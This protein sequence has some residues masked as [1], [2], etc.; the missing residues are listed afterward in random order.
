[1][2]RRLVL[3]FALV[4]RAWAAEPECIVS[5]RLPSFGLH[6]NRRTVSQTPVASARGSACTM[7]RLPRVHTE[8]YDTSES[9]QMCTRNTSTV[10][11]SLLKQ[12]ATNPEASR[13]LLRSFTASLPPEK[14]QDPHS[15]HARRMLCAACEL[16]RADKVLTPFL[17]EETVQGPLQLSFGSRVRLSTARLVA[18]HLH[19]EICNAS[20]TCPSLEAVLP[21]SCAGSS[22]LSKNFF[23]QT[24]LDNARGTADV[25]P[26]SAASDALWARKWVYCPNKRSDGIFAQ[27]QGSVDKATWLNPQTR[28][29]ACAAQI[30][31]SAATSVSV[32]FCLIHSKTTRLCE[33]MFQWRREAEAIICR[34]SGRCP[35]TDFFYSP[36]TF[37][38]REQ[39]FV[40][41]SVLDYY[42]TETGRTCAMGNDVSEQQ[43][44]NY[45]NMGRC[46]S[47]QIEPML[48]IVEQLR[49]G[50]R[51]LMLIGYHYYRVQFYL[52]QL[53]VSATMDTAASLASAGTDTLGRVADSLLREVMSLMQQIGAFVDQLR[54]TVMELAMSRGAGKTIKD[55]LVVVCKI[56]EFLYTVLWSYFLCPILRI[57]LIIMEFSINIADALLNIVRIVLFGAPEVVKV[58]DGFIGTARDIISGI[59]RAIGNCAP[60]SFNCVIEPVFG[61]QD[62]DFGTLPMPTRCWSSY[63]TF[64]GDNQQSSCSKADTCKLAPLASIQERRVCG[65]CPEQS[66]PSVQD[67]ACHALTGICTC[68]V[69]ILSSTS[70][71]TNEDCMTDQDATCRLIND[72]LE[73]S[74]SSVACGDCAYQQ[75]CFETSEGGV[76]ACGARQRKMHT[77]SQTDHEEKNALSLRLEELCL[78]TSTDGVV[79]FALSSVIPCME[80]DSSLSSC[81]W[82]IDIGAFLARGFRRVRRRL[83]EHGNIQRVYTFKSVDSVCRDALLSEALPY[84]RAACQDAFDESNAT[85]QLLELQG[86]LPTCTF[87]SFA[88]ALDAARHNPVAMLQLASPRALSIILQRHGVLQR[89]AQLGAVVHGGLRELAASMSNRNASQIVI[90]QRNAGTITVRVSDA[91]VPAHIARALEQFL[92][93]VLPTLEAFAPRVVNS[94]NTSEATSLQHSR[95]LLLFRELVLAVE[96]R[97][98]TG[99]NQAG[100]LHEAFSQ[101]IELVLTYKYAGSS[102]LANDLVW[103]P[104]QT[105]GGKDTCTELRDLL[106]IFITVGEGIFDGWLTL[107]HE[108]E[109]LQSRP[110]ESLAAAWPVLLRQDEAEDGPTADVLKLR[111]SSSDDVITQ[112]CTAG[113]SAAFEAAGIDTRVFYDI[114]YSVASA[115]NASFTCPYKAVQT[116]S[117]WNRRLYQAVIIVVLWFCAA[118]LFI[119][120][121]GLTFV[122]SLLVPF[123]SLVVMQLCYGYTWTCLPMVPVCWWQ[124]FT[125]SVN[126][127]LPLSLEIPDELKRLDRHCLVVD[128]ACVNAGAAAN[129]CLSLQR[130]PQA[131]CLKSCREAPFGFVSWQHVLAWGLAETGPAT[132]DAALAALKMLP[133]V[134]HD[135][136]V[137][138]VRKRSR[139]I[140][141]AS[142]DSVSAHRACAMLNTYMLLPYVLILMLVLAFLTSFMQTLASQ[143]FPLFNVLCTLG[144]AIAISAH[145]NDDVRKLA[146][147]SKAEV[148][149]DEGEYDENSVGIAVEGS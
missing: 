76:C 133:L 60:K 114:F 127:L 32:E 17:Q 61:E 19:R 87:C 11:C 113:A 20:D 75:M 62:S 4:A 18:A 136:L 132:A 8:V 95:R 109:R 77:C 44:A 53:L 66:N 128:T 104:V 31:I 121:L 88:D 39:Q 10:T 58:L 56:V 119:N 26:A 52:V 116:C 14:G 13:Q 82:A 69:P 70:C 89:T 139:T 106:N 3:L 5:R 38:L 16:Q 68:G 42:R 25:A 63:L 134:D 129:S 93:N 37:D 45:V 108:R 80:L 147:T 100:R 125:E 54:D 99:W 24:L 142:V 120:T 41:D 79:E 74:K 105:T 124:D 81:V 51:V 90:V 78:Y 1:M 138:E 131:R 47:V 6:V 130:Y 91:S 21:A 50:K 102:G 23:L 126:M 36:T 146:G 96:E 29:R 40:Y 117:G 101:S 137:T 65:A 46:A 148:E 72:D 33:R 140:Q 22:C 71:F 92:E 122:S 34:A 112:T 94:S 57:C 9:V 107:T 64:F 111:V 67:F 135:L 30:P 84:T 28:A 144:S 145:A 97:V 123:F 118:A 49:E 15:P 110:T 48:T 141:R 98:R 12:N 85:L 115:A 149:D 59:T 27:C 43:A 83:L 35:T 86:Q 103:P 55:I 143:L 73:V 7:G 2:A